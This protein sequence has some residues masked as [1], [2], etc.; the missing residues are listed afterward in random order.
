MIQKEDDDE[1]HSY[2]IR[3]SMIRENDSSIYS[4]GIKRKLNSRQI[5]MISLGGI[6]GY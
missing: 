4:N 3:D 2:Q 1:I 6:I 5:Q